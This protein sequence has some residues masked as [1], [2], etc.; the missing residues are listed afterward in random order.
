[1]EGDDQNHSIKLPEDEATI[2]ELKSAVKKKWPNALRDIDEGELRVFAAAAAAAAANPNSNNQLANEMN[3]FEVV[4]LPTIHTQHA[5]NIALPLQQQPPPP[6]LPQ[7]SPMLD[8]FKSHNCG[9]TDFC[10]LC[11]NIYHEAT[12]AAVKKKKNNNNNRVRVPCKFKAKVLEV[13]NDELCNY[14]NELVAAE[15]WQLPEITNILSAAL[16]T[17]NLLFD[18]NADRSETNK[19]PQALLLLSVRGRA[20]QKSKHER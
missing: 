8:F 18:V 17:P 10:V 12:A 7:L 15:G 13:A 2:E 1:L 4:P 20:Q 9:N 16:P 3:I 6:S 19:Y 11:C 5:L 14:C